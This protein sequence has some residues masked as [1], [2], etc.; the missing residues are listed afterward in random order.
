MNSLLRHP[1]WLPAL[2]A[3]LGAAS[4]GCIPPGIAWFPDSTGFVYTGGKD[5]KQ[6]TVFELG[7]QKGRALPVTVGVPAWPAVS[8]DGKRIAVAW[9]LRDP[10]E[11][12]HM[13]VMVVDRA[14]KVVHHSRDLTDADVKGVLQV[15]WSPR[16]DKLLVCGP[17]WGRLYDLK[18]EKLTR[19]SGHAVTFGTTPVRPDGKAFLVFDRRGE[20]HLVD[21]D[22]KGQVIKPGFAA[23]GKAPD[24]DK[25]LQFPLYADS[26][27]DG[28]VASVAWKR[29]RFRIDTVKLSITKEDHKAL[30][31]GAGETV[32][33]AFSFPGRATARVI[34]PDKEARPTA[35]P[36]LEVVRPG[37]APEALVKKA[38]FL[39]VFPSPDGKWLAVRWAE[40]ITAAFGPSKKEDRILVLNA[41]GEVV[42]NLKVGE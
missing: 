24:V 1:R 31:T 4:A 42:A 9:A 11:K 19:L 6:L 29:C 38:G 23:L 26:R 3:L 41:R 33:V 2:A 8:P 20:Y 21:W 36:R 35:G 16:G 28:P 7:Q 18:T 34:D 27:W 32:R 25:L 5:K 40:D 15:S 14:G 17:G 37:K 30:Q 12:P 22:G 10:D 39:M 13:T